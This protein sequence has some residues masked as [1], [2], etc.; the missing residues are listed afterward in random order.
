MAVIVTP[1]DW[2]AWA[3]W[4]VKAKI[5]LLGDGPVSDVTHVGHADYPLLWPLLWAFSSWFT[6]GWE[7]AWSR[8]WGTVLYVFVLWELAIIIYRETGRRE[9]GLFAAALFATIPSVP[10]IVSWSYAET[11]L[12]LFTICCT[13]VLF[14]WRKKGTMFY[15][16]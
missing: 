3:I 12:W 2:D 7:D 10:L 9:L 5:L 6:A 11:P 13:G 16:S 1:D 15:L 8:G 4:G 14:L